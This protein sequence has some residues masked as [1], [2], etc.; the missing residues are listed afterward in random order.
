MTT[1][2]PHIVGKECRFAVHIPERYNVHPDIHMVK[3]QV[4]YSDGTIRPQIKYVKDFKRKVYITPQSKRRYKQKKEWTELDQVQVQET[5][6][7]RM[8]DLVARGLGKGHSRDHMKL[9]AQSPYLYGTDILSTCL[10]KKELYMDVYPNLSTPYTIGTYDIETDVNDGSEDIIMASFL[11][12][13]KAF[14][15]VKKSFIQGIAMIDEQFQDACNRYIGTYLKKHDMEVVLHIAEDVV[16]LIKAVFEEI[17]RAKPDFLA[18]WNMNFDIPKTLSQLEKFGV[19]PKDVFCDPGVPKIARICKY[20]EG[21]SKKTTASGKVIPINPAA[22]WHTLFLTA[23]FYVIDAMCAFKHL[24]L[25]EQEEPSYS[26]D[27]ILHKILGIRKLSFIQADNYSG[28]QKHQ[29]MQ[30]NYKLEYMVYN[31]FDC[32]SMLELDLTT[33]DLAYTLPTFAATTDFRDFKSQPRRIA[34]ALHFFALTQDCVMGT[35]GQVEEPIDQDTEAYDGESDEELVA[36]TTLSAEGWIL[37]LAPHMSVH[38]MR[39]IR[40]DQ[41]IQTNIRGFV[42]DS[43]TVS[44]YPT[45]TSVANVSKTTTKKEVIRIDG[46]DEE[47]FRMQNLNLVVG[48]VNASEYCQTMFGLAEPEDLLAEFTATLH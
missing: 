9:L 19:D 26:L 22:R 44:S 8:R 29:F 24:R 21:P 10:V 7:S 4:H 18:I 47:V 28:L 1:A 23:S 17:H 33:K 38:G 12:K 37:T 30:K 32:L 45:C 11:F 3:E 20:K 16:D 48:E 14:I 41:T 13:K 2:E 25:G 42:Y 5:T 15:S 31:I 43:D 35:V 36:A 39:C 46:I 34:D 40:E 6:Q 27:A